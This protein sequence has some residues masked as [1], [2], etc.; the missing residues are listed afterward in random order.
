MQGLNL[1]RHTIFHHAIPFA[2]NL[3]PTSHTASQLTQLAPSLI[4]L[5]PSLIA[6]L[7]VLSRLIA[8]PIVLSRHLLCRF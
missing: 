5:A 4:A 3:Q 8:S 6:S 2:P 7:I 1:F